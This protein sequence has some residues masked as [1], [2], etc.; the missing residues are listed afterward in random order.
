MIY[1]IGES[2]Q[3]IVFSEDVLAHFDTHRQTRWWHREA[4]GQLFARFDLPT[5]T[6][7]EATGPRRGDCRSCNSYRPDRRAEQREIASRHARGLHFIG[8]WHT[9]PEDLPSPSWHDDESMREMFSQSEHA[10][11]GFLLVIAGR[12]PFPSGLAVWMYDHTSQIRLSKL[13]TS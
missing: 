11:R 12:L 8:D 5:I 3:R 10:L 9:H 13:P 4:G 6:V 2:G 1:P 7:V